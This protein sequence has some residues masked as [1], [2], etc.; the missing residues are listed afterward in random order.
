MDRRPC[1]IVAYS[2]SA[3]ASRWCRH[4]RR[5]GWAVHSTPSAPE[6]DRLAD[7]FEPA[8]IVV[9]AEMPGE[10][11]NRLAAYLRHRFPGVE[12]V[13]VEAGEDTPD[14]VLEQLQ[15]RRLVGA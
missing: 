11:V 9:D 15:S 14:V 1:L 6:I 8:A 13:L 3:F 7:Q 12:I 4:F 5:N 10:S 2:D